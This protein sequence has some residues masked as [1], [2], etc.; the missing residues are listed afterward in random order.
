MK[1]GGMLGRLA[2]TCPTHGK[3]IKKLK[4]QRNTEPRYAHAFLL[5]CV[6]LTLNMS[7]EPLMQLLLSLGVYYFVVCDIKV[8][9]P[10]AP[11]NY[12]YRWSITIFHFFA[13]VSCHY[14]ITC[15]RNDVKLF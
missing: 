8:S 10:N 13:I 7:F 6:A 1:R 4:L 5:A 9:H 3:E 15:C 2:A 14:V 11:W 12:C